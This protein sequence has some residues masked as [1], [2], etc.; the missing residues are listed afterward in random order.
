MMIRT[1]IIDTTTPMTIIDDKLDG[2][3]GLD[4]VEMIAVVD[5]SV[6]VV[7]STV[8]TDVVVLVVSVVVLVVSGMV[9]VVL[10]A[11]V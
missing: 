4:C 10:L 3:I 11:V 6:S 5:C 7:G 2:G 1:I 8:V 9:L